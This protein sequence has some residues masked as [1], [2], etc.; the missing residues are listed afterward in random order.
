MIKTKKLIVF[1]LCLVF[2]L[3]VSAL[4]VC[5]PEDGFLP[6]WKKEEKIIRFS[7]E[8]LF[9]YI[10]GGSE[11]F[12]EFGFKELLV[13]NY[14]KAEQEIGIDIYKMEN[15]EAALGIYLMKCGKETPQPEIAARNSFDI[16]QCAVIKNNYFIL[17][18]NFKGNKALIPAMVKVLQTILNS[19]S[20]IKTETVL[21]F[22]PEKGLIRGSEKIIRGPFALQ[23]I[24]TFGQ[25]DILNLGG[26][27][28]GAVADYQNSQNDTYTRILI[29]YPDKQTAIEAYKHLISN[30][31]SYL[32]IQET[33]E[34]AF[35]FKDYKGE[36]GFVL[37]IGSHLNIKI[38]LKLPASSDHQVIPGY[39]SGL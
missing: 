19:I 32:K 15:P 7:P 20:D 27:T 25:G 12:L 37:I 17:V 33:S 29:P 28:F 2:P 6:E 4:Q 3:Q 8:N 30:L 31:D 34:N 13:Q 21:A 23:P 35:S 10:N 9:N 22:L 26:K 14:R 36:Y 39:I 16:H 5:L 24:F 38:H 18:N 11:L 1:I